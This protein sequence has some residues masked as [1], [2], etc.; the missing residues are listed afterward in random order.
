MFNIFKKKKHVESAEER[1]FRQYD[2][3]VGGLINGLI[4]SH[5]ATS[6]VVYDTKAELE[7]LNMAFEELSKYVYGQKETEQ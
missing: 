7:K 1:L 6:E 3:V 2:E 4:E 5:I